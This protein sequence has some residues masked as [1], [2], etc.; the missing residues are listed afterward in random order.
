MKSFYFTLTA[1]VKLVLQHAGCSGS[2]S[3][4][5]CY[6]TELRN[7]LTSLNT[8]VFE[9][10]VKW[11]N[12]VNTWTGSIYLVTPEVGTLHLPVR[13]EMP[14][15]LSFRDRHTDKYSYLICYNEYCY[16]TTAVKLIFSFYTPCRHKGEWRYC[17]T[18]SQC[19]HQMVVNGQFHALASVPWGKATLCP[20]SRR[21]D[22]LQWQSGCFA[23]ETNVL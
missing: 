21:L 12:G 16:K 19:L 11:T 1:I 5:K 7:I 4:I 8:G 23:Q 20:Q 18:H 6:L 9:V 22:W 14:C 10:R 13:S 2:I 17:S 15:R 3:R